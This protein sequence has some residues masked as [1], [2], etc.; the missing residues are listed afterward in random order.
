MKKTIILMLAL[1][2]LS[3]VVQASDSTDMARGQ[4]AVAGMMDALDGEPVPVYRELKRDLAAQLQLVWGEAEY[5]A[6]RSQT[7]EKYGRMLSYRFHAFERTEDFDRFMY[8]GQ[9]TKERR[10]LMIYALDKQGK[11]IAYSFRPYKPQ[12]QKK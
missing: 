7:A 10:V 4:R 9:F 3:G 12:S 5:A 1:L 6:M 8:I 2:C 11:I